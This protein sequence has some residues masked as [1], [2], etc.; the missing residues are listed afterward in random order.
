MPH[1]WKHSG[2]RLGCLTGLS[3]QF[4][5]WSLSADL[6]HTITLKDLFTSC[7]INNCSKGN[8]RVFT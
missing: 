7:F 6:S 8:I 2:V 1:V 4:L 3:L 5:L